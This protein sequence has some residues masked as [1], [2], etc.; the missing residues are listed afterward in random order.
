M[1]H[2]T[3]V[4][5]RQITHRQNARPTGTSHFYSALACNVS[6]R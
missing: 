5:D 2:F 1:I 6:R 4:T 3:S